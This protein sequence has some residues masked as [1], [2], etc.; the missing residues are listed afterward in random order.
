MTLSV[1]YG[2]CVG[3][4]IDWPKEAEEEIPNE[5]HTLIKIGESRRAEGS[6]F[7]KKPS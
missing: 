3:V 7:S 4:T 2:A 5:S 1:I 6:A